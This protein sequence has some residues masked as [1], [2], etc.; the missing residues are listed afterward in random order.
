MRLSKCVHKFFPLS[1]SIQLYYFSI[2][3]WVVLC[4]GVVCA[5][6]NTDAIDENMVCAAVNTIASSA[7]Y[8]LP[9]CS[10]NCFLLGRQPA[11]ALWRSFIP[12]IHIASGACAA[13]VRTFDLAWEICYFRSNYRSFTDWFIAISLVAFHHCVLCLVMLCAECVYTV[14]KVQMLTVER[15]PSRK[16]T[17]GV[18]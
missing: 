5:C 13:F 7:A 2:R 8:P 17:F 9:C 3:L 1:A 4:A 12:W 10:F 15:L 6:S 14:H 16:W 11:Y 18:A